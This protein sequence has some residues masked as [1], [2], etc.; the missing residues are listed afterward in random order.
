MHGLVIIPA[1]VGLHFL[2]LH[3]ALK[4]VVLSVAGVCVSWALTV[5]LKKVPG[6]SKV[7]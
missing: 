3:P 1:A 7:M 4:W 2:P 6:V 5:A